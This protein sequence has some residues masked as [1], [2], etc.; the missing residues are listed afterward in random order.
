MSRPSPASTAGTGIIAAAFALLLALA[1]ARAEDGPQPTLDEALSS[2]VSEQGWQ[3]LV[4]STLDAEGVTRT[5]AVGV[6]D[7]RSGAA[8]SADDR[9]HVGSV[10]KTVLATGVLHLVTEG[11]FELD[12]PVAT[13]LP[14]VRFD[15]PW[16]ATDPVR[17]RHL[18]D[19]TAGL[20]DAR[21]ADVFSLAADAD[22][23]LGAFAEGRTLA[24]RSRPGSRHSYSNTGYAL[25]G[26]VIE[27]STGEHY[28]S[29]LDRT[30]LRPLGMHR[31]TF[32]FTTQDGPRADAS[33]AMGHF[34]GGQP[35]AAVP[36]PLRPAMQF[37]TTAGDMARLA[38][39]LMGDGTVDGR[40]LVRADLLAAMGQP[41]GSEA[42]KAGL[43]VGYG[44]GMATR[45][46]HGAVG[47]CHGGST[48]G[49]R[50]IFCVFPALRTAFFT[51][52]NSDHEG[53]DYGRLDRLLIES[54]A[55]PPFEPGAVAG[56]AGEVAAGFYVPAPNRFARFAWLDTTLNFVRVDPTP[57]GLRFAPFQSP[58]IVLEPLGGGLY[59]APG[60]LLASHAV[61]VASDGQPV[62]STGHQ[63]WARASTATM[64][65][66]WTSL[67]AGLLGLAWLLLCGLPR[68]AFGA[69][70]RW[71]QPL[72]AP[73]LGVLL[74]ALPV[75]FFFGQSFLAMGDLTLAS[76]LLAAVTLLLPV[77]M[78]VGLWRVWRTPRRSRWQ[79]AD[80]LAMAV[81]LQ[82]CAVLA[83]WGLLPMRTW[84]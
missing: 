45:D 48:V 58:A 39:F 22:A 37:T 11:R 6:R 30:L 29:Y 73:C 7:A 50:A 10:A 13:L 5:G 40:L 76:G 1:P 82:W 14:Q 15:N 9:V 83:A 53:A 77:A 46:R 4:W 25:L 63:T 17:L 55:I 32:A 60:R 71:R 75:P 57:E 3:G 78:L 2:L 64:L 12:T 67:A 43:P 69:R 81:V 31:S 34:E 52:V 54:L 66:L 26:M 16:A 49:Y 47:R 18:L 51:S 44:L 79:L 65:A 28:E 38:A 80:A 19:H 33:V 84:A 59:R 8:I 41:V 36:A 61:T 20:D 42:A 74:L 70:P 35:Q 23:P 24:V 27:A 72:A 68:L 21:L 62:I 56:A